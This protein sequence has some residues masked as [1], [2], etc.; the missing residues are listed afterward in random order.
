MEYKKKHGY[1][2]AHKYEIVYD[3]HNLFILF[4]HLLNKNKTEEIKNV[5]KILGIYKIYRNPRGLDTV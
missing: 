5:Y 2:L 3:F 4:M 1:I